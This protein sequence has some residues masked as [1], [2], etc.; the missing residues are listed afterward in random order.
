M[1]VGVICACL[2]SLKAL[3]K[4]YFPEFFESS[5]VGLGRR[6]P[7]FDVATPSPRQWEDSSN[8]FE[9]QEST[10]TGTSVQLKSL[11]TNSEYG[12]FD[13]RNPIRPSIS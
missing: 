9:G 12:G 8:I 11:A 7:S 6:I 2:P 13:K 1:Y 5:H 3:I 4:R 10:N